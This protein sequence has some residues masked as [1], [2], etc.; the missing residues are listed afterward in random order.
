MKDINSN[1][2]ES[3]K[4]VPTKEINANENQKSKYSEF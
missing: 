4:F 3:I 2:R 1:K